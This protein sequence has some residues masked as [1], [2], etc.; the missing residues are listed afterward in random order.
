MHRNHSLNFT[1]QTPA[2]I[3]FFLYISIQK[4]PSQSYVCA[5]VSVCVV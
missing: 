4:N 1:L 5:C 2:I 3:A